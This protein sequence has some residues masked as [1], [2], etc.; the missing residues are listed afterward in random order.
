MEDHRSKTDSSIERFIGT[1]TEEDAEEV[2][3]QVLI[4]LTS[5]SILSILIP[6]LRDDEMLLAAVKEALE[7]E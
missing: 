2:F 7:D 4:N 5:E 1:C 3:R 6:Y